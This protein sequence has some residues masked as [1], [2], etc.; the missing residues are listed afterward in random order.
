MKIRIINQKSKEKY[1]YIY[2]LIDDLSLFLPVTIF[3][4]LNKCIQ[5][6]IAV[7]YLRGGTGP[8]KKKMYL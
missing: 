1:M 7:V 4:Y 2:W 3:L 6:N 5:L 8:P